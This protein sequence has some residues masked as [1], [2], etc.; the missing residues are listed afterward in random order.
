MISVLFVAKNSI[1]KTLSDSAGEPLDCW[2]EDRDAM[3][4]PGG[5]TI[6]AH[7]PCRLF[8]C[9]RHLSTAPAEEKRLAH[10]AVEQVREWGGVLEHPA[11]SLLWQ[12]ASLPKPGSR[13]KFGGLTLSIDQFWWGHRASKPTLLYV[14]GC[15]R[16]PEIPFAIGFPPALMSNSRKANRHGRL[17]LS[18]P[19]R[20]ATP[21]P[22][23]RWLIQTAERCKAKVTK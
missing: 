7:P 22:F 11:R 9:L 3:K 15:E 21:E 1:Y 16:V 13:D 4:W 17:L 23:A 5:N 10:W 14:V 6:V 12:E 19:A 20:S 8:S 18:R 2:D